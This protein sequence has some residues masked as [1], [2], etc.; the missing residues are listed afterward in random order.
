MIN[1]KEVLKALKTND[2][3]TI[4]RIFPTKSK[5]QYYLSIV[6]IS[7]RYNPNKPGLNG[8]TKPISLVNLFKTT[9]EEIRV[10]NREFISRLEF[11]SPMEQAIHYA[12]NNK[13]SIKHIISN[14]YRITNAIFF[15]ACS[16]SNIAIIKQFLK[17][18]SKY[19]KNEII[20]ICE[21]GLSVAI[22]N[23]QIKT[24]NLLT[25]HLKALPSLT[26]SI[27]RIV[28]IQFLT[29]C[30][31]NQTELVTET[32]SQNNPILISEGIEELIK[33]KSDNDY[34]KNIYLNHY[35]PIKNKEDTK[36]LFEVFLKEQNI[37]LFKRFYEAIA[38]DNSALE[39][40]FHSHFLRLA[41][42]FGF[43]ELLTCKKFMSNL[44][45]IELSDV[46]KHIF[47]LM[48]D[49]NRFRKNMKEEKK[50][51]E[52]NLV[53]DS[54]KTLLSLN[55]IKKNQVEKLLQAATRR[56]IVQLI[57]KAISSNLLKI[58]NSNLKDFCNSV[59]TL[60]MLKYFEDKLKIRLTDTHLILSMAAIKNSLETFEYVTNNYSYDLTLNN[61]LILKKATSSELI[62][63]I[64]NRIQV[65][66]SQTE[67]GIIRLSNPDLVK[68][69]EMRDLFFGLHQD[70][71]TNTTNAKKTLKI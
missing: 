19:R 2:R 68:K 50:E 57:D 18:Q 30:K 15:Y 8:N 52:I 25:K 66:L 27:D 60:D 51:E 42:L 26:P 10:A 49:S 65:K 69:I 43:S 34:I 14:N 59:N 7:D 64:T 39:K 58:N 5:K 20:S 71:K 36:T 17:T 24:I 29:A 6:S 47:S 11:S 56:G 35:L 28:E 22:Q 4:R 23:N 48:S 16:I 38:D 37:E 33:N 3:A 32:L 44:S 41:I 63:F 62:D 67:L 53:V 13:I 9:N 70:L 46:Y 45:Q 61:Y 54:L 1:K 31:N 21:L 40:N 12:L 55:L